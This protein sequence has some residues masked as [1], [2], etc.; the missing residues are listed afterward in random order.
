M[1]REELVSMEPRR[2][3]G[4]FQIVFDILRNLRVPMKPSH[5]MMKINMNQKTLFRHMPLLLEKGFVKEVPYVSD[6]GKR[7]SIVTPYLYVVTEKG[8]DLIRLFEQVYKVLG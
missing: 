8:E 7:M 1:P 5:L 2:R 4:Q 6:R 3:R